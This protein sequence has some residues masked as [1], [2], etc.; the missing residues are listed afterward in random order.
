MPTQSSKKSPKASKSSIKV[1][2][3]W[4]DSQPSGVISVIWCTARLLKFVGSLSASL[5]TLVIPEAR[6]SQPLSRFLLF[7]GV[8]LFSSQHS[9][10][11]LGSCG[12][13]NRIYF[14]L[15]EI[16]SVQNVLL[17]TVHLTF[18]NYPIN[19]TCIRSFQIKRIKRVRNGLLS[20]ICSD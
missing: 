9:I 8:H 11:V 16:I 3:S 10:P 7:S 14:I 13:E 12:L 4:N 18:Q 5:L 19:C 15:F 1:F 6:D 17:L 20:N 2:L